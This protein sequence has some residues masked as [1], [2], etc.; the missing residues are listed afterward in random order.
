MHWLMVFGNLLMSWLFGIANVSDLIM[1]LTDRD[2][3]GASFLL[4]FVP[5]R[6]PSN[7]AVNLGE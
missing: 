7:I 3:S 5:H 6:L 1:F 2:N 4:V